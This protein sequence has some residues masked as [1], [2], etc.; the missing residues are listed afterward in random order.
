MVFSIGLR[1]DLPDVVGSSTCEVLY[2]GTL[3]VKIREN[4]DFFLVELAEILGDSHVAMRVQIVEFDDEVV[5]SKVVGYLPF[6]GSTGEP[7][8]E[9]LLALHHGLIWFGNPPIQIQIP[10]LL[11]ISLQFSSK[12]LFVV[13]FKLF[14]DNSN[15]S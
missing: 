13:L 3:T 7:P 15:D 4:D 11:V 5:P 8:P 9:D 14:L 2:I 10:A 6:E 1:S 12:G